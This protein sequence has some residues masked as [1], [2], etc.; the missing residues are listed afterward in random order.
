VEKKKGRPGQSVN[1]GFLDT[2]S[3]SWSM[4]L[5]SYFLELHSD[6]EQFFISLQSI[7]EML[8]VLLKEFKGM[9]PIEANKKRVQEE[10][11]QEL[12]KFEDNKFID[13]VAG[14]KKSDPS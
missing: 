3:L 4:L 9:L 10:G 12:K 14:S 6:E 8:E 1:E 2:G 5:A 13:H 11:P 7:C